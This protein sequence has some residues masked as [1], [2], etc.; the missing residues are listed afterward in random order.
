MKT[1]TYKWK[2]ICPRIPFNYKQDK[3]KMYG[4]FMDTAL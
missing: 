4:Q 3:D 2:L 1:W